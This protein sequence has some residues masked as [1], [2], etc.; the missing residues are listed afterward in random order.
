[1]RSVAPQSLGLPAPAALDPAA[2]GWVAPVG[3]FFLRKA[4]IT[5]ARRRELPCN[6]SAAPLQVASQVELTRV[7]LSAVMSIGPLDEGASWAWAER[8]SP[9]ANISPAAAARHAVMVRSLRAA[10]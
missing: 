2:P 4:L 9:P 1:M 7:P 8:P 10:P 3:G 5:L 6:A